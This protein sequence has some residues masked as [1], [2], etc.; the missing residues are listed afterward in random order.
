MHQLENVGLRVSPPKD[1]D[2]VGNVAIALLE[3][4][5]IA[6]MHPEH[7]RLSQLLSRAIG[8]LNSKL[9]L[10]SL[11]LACAAVDGDANNY[12]PNAA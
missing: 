3:A 1:L 2:A 11:P 12:S 9:R 5:D 10:A 4:G 8:M 7:P 6:G